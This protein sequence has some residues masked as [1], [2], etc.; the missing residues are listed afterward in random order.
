MYEALVD[1]YRELNRRVISFNEEW[2]SYVVDGHVW[3][4]PVLTEH[5]TLDVVE[6][7]VV[8]ENGK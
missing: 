6:V 1:A 2:P 7:G 3:T 5:K 4:L 8:S